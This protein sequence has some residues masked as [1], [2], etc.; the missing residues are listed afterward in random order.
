[1]VFQSKVGW[2]W[3]GISCWFA[4]FFNDQE[5]QIFKVIT[6]PIVPL[7]SGLL[8]FKHVS[9]ISESDFLFVFT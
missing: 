8:M 4:F 3:K 1:M 9:Q 6:W 7:T 2:Q 5:K